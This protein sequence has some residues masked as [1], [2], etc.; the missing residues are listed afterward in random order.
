MSHELHPEDRLAIGEVLS[1]HGHLFDGG[2]L[3][4]LGEIFTPTS[5]TT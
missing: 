3:G 1:L 2:H 4:R 5:S